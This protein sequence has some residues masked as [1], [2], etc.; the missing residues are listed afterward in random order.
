MPG[1]NAHDVT[2]HAILPAPRLKARVR[3]VQAAAGASNSDRLHDAL[4]SASATIVTA[5]NELG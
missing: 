2:K 3:L 4:A 5:S 1:L